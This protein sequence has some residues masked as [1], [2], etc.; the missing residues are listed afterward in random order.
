MRGRDWLIPTLACYLHMS[1][2][3]AGLAAVTCRSQTADSFV[4]RGV[5]EKE[6]QELVSIHLVEV[7]ALVEVAGIQHTNAVAA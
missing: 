5:N 2:P 6:A 1:H 7:G 4:D 3:R